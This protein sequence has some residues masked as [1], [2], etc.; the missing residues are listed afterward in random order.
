MSKLAVVKCDPQKQRECSKEILKNLEKHN[1][2]YLAPLK[3]QTKVPT[4]SNSP[5][6]EG[7]IISSGGS[8]EGPNLCFQSTKNLT[9]S[10]L[11]TGTWLK[12]HGLNPKDCIIL[13]SLPLHHVSGFMPWWRHHVWGTQ[14]HW[15]TNSMMHEPIELENF[16]KALANRYRRPLITSLVPTQ[17]LSLIDNPHGL[18]WLQ[19]L[20]MIWVGGASIPKDLANKAR[21]ES[22][23]LAP[24]YGTTETVAMVTCLSPRDFLNGSDNVGFPL[25]DVEIKINDKN[26]LKIKTCRIAIKKWKNNKFES[27]TDSTG[28]W[29][30]GDLAQYVT[31][32]NKKA[33]KILGRRDSAINSG[34]ETIFPEDVSMK[35]MTIIAKNQIPIKDIF[36]LG[37]TDQKWGQRLAGLIRFKEKEINKYQIVSLLTHLI[38]DWQP[39]QK[40]LNWYDCPEL[41]KNINKKWELSRWQK[42]LTFNT[43]IS[44]KI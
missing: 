34:G 13:N 24:C 25:E 38:K 9:S 42:W 43:P 6:G 1:W 32:N 3:D 14:H 44:L 19:S 33:L 7:I 8:I 39:S 35:L 23:N 41:S 37:V 29:E 31:L 20:S 30:A 16:S 22:I 26:L 11:A 15:I 28:W 5:S 40:P 4:P 21:S 36:V 17:L 2:V 10:A 18:K 12:D 27:I